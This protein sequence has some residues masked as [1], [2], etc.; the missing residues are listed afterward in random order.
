MT[1]TEAKE[2]AER[3]LTAM[4]VNMTT[5]EREYVLG[6]LVNY[7]VGI[8]GEIEHLRYEILSRD[9]SIKSLGD[10]LRRIRTVSIEGASCD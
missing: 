9:A 7:T 4:P 6:Q 1:D 10:E 5:L 3:F 2:R 8:G